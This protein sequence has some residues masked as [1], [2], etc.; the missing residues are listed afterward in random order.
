LL[1][2]ALVLSPLRSPRSGASLTW[3]LAAGPAVAMPLRS[4]A[5]QALAGNAMADGLPLF[6]ALA[7]ERRDALCLPLSATLAL[8]VR[9][10][11]LAD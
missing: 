2:L 8:E 4:A 5:A 1:G 7:L 11:A 3:S 10:Q 6:E 9:L